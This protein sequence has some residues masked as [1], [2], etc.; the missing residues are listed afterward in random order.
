MAY[1]A[2]TASAV[3][4]VLSCLALG[5]SLAQAGVS[6]ATIP[7]FPTTVTVGQTGLSGTITLIS[8]NSGTEES[9]TNTVTDV[10]LIPACSKVAGTSCDPAGAEPGVFEVAATASGEVGSACGGKVFD[11]AVVDA[12]FGTVRFT[13][14][15]GPATLPGN[16]ATCRIIVPFA[17][18]KRPRGD[19]DATSAERQLAELASGFQRSSSG[20][21]GGGTGSDST[22]V[23]RATPALATSASPGVTLASGALT[24]RATVS[25]RGAPLPGATVEFRLHG[26]GDNSC[27]G[28]PVFRATA[29]L[30]DAGTATSP[31]FTP[32][33]TGTYRWRALYSG[34]DNNA[35]VDGACDDPNQRVTVAAVGEA[36]S[37]P[38][39]GGTTGPEILGA[40]FEAAPRVGRTAFLRVRARDRSQPISGV[41][42]GFDEPGGLTGLTACRLPAVR[43]TASTVR[44]RV[45]YKFRRAGRHRV[46]IGVLSGDCFGGLRRTEQSIDVDVGKRKPAKAVTAPSGCAYRNLIPTQANLT[47]SRVAG[48]VMCLVNVERR[49][50]GL[51]T[52]LRSPR[53]VLA[54]ARHSKDMVRRR[55]FSHE[56]LSGTSFDV[57]L[58]K[59]GYRGTTKAENI[60][61][62]SYETAELAVRAWM[63]SP[64]HR[65]N[66]LHRRLRF[67]G[68]GL[69]VGIPVSPRLPGATYTMDYGSAPR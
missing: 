41:Q 42:V 57:R 20:V 36:P 12:T 14:R 46:S 1:A 28:V 29:P 59:A 54:A 65:S 48:A 53:L 33:E 38:T 61:Y 56:S 30:S 49:R 23:Q 24:D 16:G 19:L 64:P 34:D 45:P 63:N 2:R 62:G 13:A 52:L 50:R 69:A 47:R 17:V 40:T 58:S 27:S 44:L 32:T 37:G 22:T 39:G 25:G 3:L 68:V 10:T 6:G 60:G 67:A 31:P 9:E 66:I 15:N 55:Y 35:P 4:A 8:G 21:T 11:V 5:P 7:S 51:A 26:P 43:P 18:L